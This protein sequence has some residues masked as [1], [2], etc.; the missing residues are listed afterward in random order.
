MNLLS[1]RDDDPA[2]FSNCRILREKMTEEEVVLVVEESFL[3]RELLEEESV[4]EVTRIVL[5]PL[6]SI[7][8]HGIHSG[9]VRL[10]TDV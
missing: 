1:G 4:A 10:A 5:L 8:G 2:F 3:K 9:L 7:E 6:S